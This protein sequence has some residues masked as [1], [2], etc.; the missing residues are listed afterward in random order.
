[1][2]RVLLHI[3]ELK[4]SMGDAKFSPNRKSREMVIIPT[5]V[6]ANLSPATVKEVANQVRLRRR[7]G[8]IIILQ[9]TTEPLL[10][11]AH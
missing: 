11:D 9:G 7:E 8:S 2:L 5:P 4:F 1:M 10:T 6:S 3:A